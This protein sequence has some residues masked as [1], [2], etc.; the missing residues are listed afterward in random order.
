MSE[1]P[2]LLPFEFGQ[3]ED[4]VLL[5]HGFTGTPYEMRYLGERLAAQ[6]FRVKGVRLAGHGLDPIAF[7]QANAD[8]WVRE[9]LE[10]LDSLAVGARHLF[11]AGLSMG[12]LLAVIL[13]AERPANVSGI[14]LLAPAFRFHGT[15][16]L[17]MWLFRNGPMRRLLRYI[18]KGGSA[19]LDGEQRR[20]NP[21][22]A[23]VPTSGAGELGSM[24]DRAEEALPKVHAPALVMY[25]RFDPTV[26]P[27]AAFL[28]AERMGSKPVRMVE[29]TR[30]LHVIT[31]DNDRE[32]V[33]EE[34]GSFFRE[35]SAADPVPMSRG[36]HG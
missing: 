33:A 30:S 35:L 6:G 14:A 20:A 23:R 5:I 8:Q 1:D 7:G 26:A 10:A 32:R 22:I 19:V 4:A 28:A 2:R 17:F 15:V 21:S 12:A 29:V 34:V 31:I 13:A 9:C 27:R 11:V 36:E 3:G 16:R 24:I 18:P 25:S